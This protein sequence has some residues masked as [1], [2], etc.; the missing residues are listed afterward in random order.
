MADSLDVIS[1]T[2]AKDPVL[3]DSYL[4]TLA[5]FGDTDALTQ[6]WDRYYTIAYSAALDHATK[7]T[8][9]SEIVTSSFD[10][11]LEHTEKRTHS[12]TFMA[13]WFV[14]IPADPPTP[15]HRAVLW[16]FYAMS[17]DNRTIVWRRTVDRWNT[18]RIDAF[19][20]WDHEDGSPSPVPQA[21]EQFGSYLTMASTA[22]GLKGTPPDFDP[23][24]WRVLLIAAMLG[25]SPEAFDEQGSP[26]DS[27][28]VIAP[29]GAPQP[30]F[31][32]TTSEIPIATVVKVASIVIVAVALAV[33]GVL[34]LTR[35]SRTSADQPLEVL[36]P[37]VL[38]SRTPTPTPKPT[39]TPSPSPTP[40]PTPTPE[41]IPTESTEPEPQPNPAPAPAPAPAPPPA[42]EPPPEPAPEP[43]PETTE[44]EPAPE[45][46]ESTWDGGDDGTTG[47]SE[48]TT[49][50]ESLS[51]ES[52]FV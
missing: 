21:E 23:S 9:A 34:G 16:A 30:T 4:F 35:W 7:K 45:T 51:T 5:R 15:L 48:G 2:H 14:D 50:D 10:H 17:Q 47:Y 33:V 41:E 13:D 3:T 26:I 39:P 36:S 29:P 11:W 38:P 6:L 18:G 22:L 52:S 31:T 46:T 32:P 43:A 1:S 28:D 19:L 42:P 12:D 8:P 24:N 20:E 44:P 49:D 27:A 25:S 37:S 40:S